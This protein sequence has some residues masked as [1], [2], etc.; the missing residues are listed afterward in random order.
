MGAPAMNP[1][2]ARGAAAPPPPSAASSPAASPTPPST[3]STG[4]SKKKIQTAGCKYAYG[5]GSILAA[6]GS[7]ALSLYTFRNRRIAFKKQAATLP[8]TMQEPAK[9]NSKGTKSNDVGEAAGAKALERLE[10]R[11]NDL[12]PAAPAQPQTDS[13]LGA[14]AF[15]DAAPPALPVAPAVAG[16]LTAQQLQLEQEEDFPLRLCLTATPLVLGIVDATII[17]RWRC[18][19]PQAPLFRYSPYPPIHTTDVACCYIHT[20]RLYQW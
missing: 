4:S 8:T 9:T 7:I 17:A 19:R 11:L 12:M 15:L 5:T 18:H 6:I 10:A 1:M 20:D 14:L 13:Q 2:G 3:S 16:Y